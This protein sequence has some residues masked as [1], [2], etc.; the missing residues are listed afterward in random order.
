MKIETTKTNVS[1]SSQ[2]ITYNKTNKN[3]DKNKN[4]NKK[5]G[6]REQIRKR[7]ARGLKKDVG[8]SWVQ[9]GSGD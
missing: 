9:V 2:N 4:K 7:K 6:K 8:C 1:L 5:K 3:H